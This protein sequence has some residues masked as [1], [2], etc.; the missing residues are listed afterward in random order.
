[1]TESQPL[2]TGGAQRKTMVAVKDTLE[3]LVES[4]DVHLEQAVRTWDCMRRVNV[5]RQR[6]RYIKLSIQL[7]EN[8]REVRDSLQRLARGERGTLE[9]AFDPEV[10]APA[11]RVLLMRTED[12][13]E[14][15][16]GDYGDGNSEV[17]SGADR[18]A[19]LIVLLTG[20]VSATEKPEGGSVCNAQLADAILGSADRKV[21]VKGLLKAYDTVAGILNAKSLARAILK[22]KQRRKA[23]RSSVRVMLR[24]HGWGKRAKETVR[25][26]Q[27]A[28]AVNVQI[29]LPDDAGELLSAHEAPGMLEGDSQ[30][31]V[32]LRSSL[33]DTPKKLRRLLFNTCGL[34]YA[35][36][37]VFYLN[38][39]LLEADQTLEE[40]GITLG[41]SVLLQLKVNMPAEGS[42]FPG[43]FPFESPKLQIQT[44]FDRSSLNQADVRI[45]G[46]GDEQLQLVI[47]PPR[48]TQETRLS[49]T[50]IHEVTLPAGSYRDSVAA[51][52]SATKFAFVYPGAS[53][54]GSSGVESSKLQQLTTHGGFVYFAEDNEVIRV[55]SMSPWS[56]RSTGSSPQRNVQPRDVGKMVSNSAPACGDQVQAVIKKIMNALGLIT[57]NVCM[58]D[59]ATKTRA[60]QV[61]AG[62]DSTLRSLCLG[63]RIPWDVEGT[64]L[65]ASGRFQVAKDQSLV[66]LGVQHICWLMPNEHIDVDTSS[67][68]DASFDGALVFLFNEDMSSHP[69]DCC[70]KMRNPEE[71]EEVLHDDS[72]DSSKLI[73]EFSRPWLNSKKNFN[74]A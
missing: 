47:C 61:M 63:P 19:K 43:L 35:W 31:A 69:A 67:F 13:E 6:P 18:F 68:A 45:D 15:G 5:D 48:A 37:G 26:S 59:E 50:P 46:A 27:E 28:R 8:L 1:M 53:T 65:K 60:S 17:T 16:E 44:V 42:E 4:Y 62:Q 39:T 41:Q 73:R 74:S 21:V 40:N 11:P 66:A 71:L 55:N 32:V 64:A 38:D 30:L 29:M 33:D 58:K 2:A 3:D 57:K 72:G 23:V 51:P 56:L 14:Q 34:P 7:I 24:L 25:A 54:E 49:L 70:F 10:L 20:G 12:D 9:A 52:H 22:V 36:E